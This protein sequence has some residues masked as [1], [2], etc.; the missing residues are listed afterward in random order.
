[1]SAYRPEWSPD[2]TQIAFMNFPAPQGFLS[3]KLYVVSADGGV[4]HR[5][6]PDDPDPAWNGTWSPDGRFILAT[7]NTFNKWKLFETKTQKWIPLLENATIGGFSTWSS[8]SQWLYYWR[9]DP[10]G[11]AG[12]YRIRIPG[13]KPELVVSLKDVHTGGW[14]KN[15]TGLDATDA[16]LIMRDIGRHEIYALTL[17][18][19]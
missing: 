16:P 17:D 3:T 4:P 5:V 13:G 14:W 12:I 18:R 7:N 15:W 9:K 1:M 2:G 11:T 8:N 6:L 19:K 10:A